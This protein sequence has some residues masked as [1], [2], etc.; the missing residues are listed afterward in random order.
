M[1]A[2]IEIIGSW[3]LEPQTSTVSTYYDYE[4]QALAQNGRLSFR[5]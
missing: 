5:K 1:G 2:A 3:G 4:I